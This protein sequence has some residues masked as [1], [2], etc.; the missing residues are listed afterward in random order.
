MSEQSTTAKLRRR[1]IS[2]AQKAGLLSALPIS[3]TG[4]E[5]AAQQWARARRTNVP[6][7][8]PV[9]TFAIP[10]VGA[11]QVTDW[12]VI[13]HTLGLTLQALIGQS[14][15]NWRAIVC[16][17][18]R[19]AVIDLDP[20]I[21]F[22]TFDQTVD[23]HDKVHKLAQLAT[24]CLAA[25]PKAGFYMPLDG[26][27]FLNI[28]FVRA[29]HAA[30]D[31]GLLVSGGYMLNAGNGHIGI[32]LP[33]SLGQPLQKPFW[34]FCG[35]CM[36]LPTGP[37]PLEETAFFKQMALHEHRLYPY[38]ATLAGHKLRCPSKPLA[39]YVINHGENF[40]SRRGRGGFKQRFIERFRI[41]A[42]S[43][44]DEIANKFPQVQQFMRPQ[45]PHTNAP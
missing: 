8:N 29:L 33:R 35:S 22:I 32:T 18:T 21:T 44:L 28:D 26:D 24:H 15:P 45:K 11:H 10:L 36:A 43:S 13:E 34:K 17:Q 1:F 4:P 27:D 20:R 12:H 9:T 38:L 40:E 14:D 31:S 39:L 41:T 30:P 2:L 3:M 25:H 23:G 19:P 6:A 7:T 37:A 5:V 42:P 16:S